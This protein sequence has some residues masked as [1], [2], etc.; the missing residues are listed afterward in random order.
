M[1]RNRNHYSFNLR[2][3]QRVDNNVTKQ[4]RELQNSI[5]HTKYITEE[6]TDAQGLEQL[7]NRVII[8]YME[9]PCI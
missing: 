9:T 8:T 5:E 1:N 3:N 7:I 2:N 4:F 6:I